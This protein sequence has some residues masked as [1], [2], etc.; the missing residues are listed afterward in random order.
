MQDTTVF[1]G[2]D[3]HKGSISIS[4]VNEQGNRVRPTVKLANDPNEL[5][6]WFARLQ[7]EGR[8]RACYEAG[9]CG[10]EVQRLL[11]KMEI[12]CEVIAPALI[13]VRPGDQVKTDCRDAEKLARLYRAGELTPIRI[14][15]EAE[16]AA[17]DLCRCRED[18]RE[19]VTRE[20]HRLAKFLLR[21][22]RVF[23]AGMAWSKAHWKWLHAQQ[24]EESAAQA[25]LVAYRSR[26]EE[27]LGRL[28][29]LDQ[30]LTALAAQEP[31][32]SQVSKL[33]CLRGI[34]TLSA[35]ILIT[36]SVTSA[37]LSTPR[38]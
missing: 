17:R 33:R 15:S 1:V 12:P 16:E 5:R 25:T 9:S 4:V 27:T 6:R 26:L 35:L 28:L 30:Q 22:G 13:P 23:T 2:M 32:K 21:H 3:V 19:D 24:L 8:P 18:V 31:F 7:K 34:E 20:R 37:A 10:Y 11:A 14:P 36:E 38:T 29:A